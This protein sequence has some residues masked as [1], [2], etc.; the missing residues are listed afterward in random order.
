MLHVTKP[1]ARVMSPNPIC[2]K[3]G[4]VIKTWLRLG[5]QK[6]EG[7][8][9]GR[10]ERMKGRKEGSATARAGHCGTLRATSGSR[11]AAVGGSG[12]SLLPASSA[13]ALP[14]LLPSTP[15]RLIV[16][17]DPQPPFR[18]F[19]F[20]ISGIKFAFR[21]SQS[22]ISVSGGASERLP[23][24]H[25]SARLRHQRSASWKRHSAA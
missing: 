16:P 15:P 2:Q 19:V 22:I 24:G 7:R 14:S 25:A 3:R 12:E 21:S 9:Q 5:L 13:P 10:K 4:S 23:G 6:K 11:A 17:L 18:S 8:K 20:G 1:K